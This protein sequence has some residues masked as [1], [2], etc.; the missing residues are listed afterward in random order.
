MSGCAS[1][2]RRLWFSERV[3]WPSE[4]CFGCAQ[5]R[6]IVRVAD[7]QRLRNLNTRAATLPRWWQWTVFVEHAIAWSQP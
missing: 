6:G 3:A 5:A 4:F 1:C 7:A 2:G